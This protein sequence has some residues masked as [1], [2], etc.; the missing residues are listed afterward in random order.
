[1]RE[2][3]ILLEI[4]SIKILVVPGFN[5][6][7]VKLFPCQYNGSKYYAVVRNSLVETLEERSILSWTLFS[8]SQVGVKRV[9]DVR[10]FSQ[11]KASRIPIKFAAFLLLG[12]V[13][14]M[15]R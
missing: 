9:G 10:V 5:Y 7:R 11:F 2:R 14:D 15:F 3:N 6:F 12:I 13:H 1:M 8:D 4:G